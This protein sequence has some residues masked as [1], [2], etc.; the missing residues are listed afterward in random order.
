MLAQ[1]GAQIIREA[2][3]FD[4]V[5]IYRFAPDQHGEV[6]AESTSREDS[7]LGLHYPA[8]DIPGPA[9]RHFVLNVFC[10]IAAIMLA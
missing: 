1:V 8:S 10:T 5:M 2:T 3:G 9:R 7:F 6:I 4:R